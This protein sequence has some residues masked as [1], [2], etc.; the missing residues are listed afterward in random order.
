MKDVDQSLTHY[1]SR[2]K[3]TYATAP[4]MA[5]CGSSKEKG[6]FNGKKCFNGK[7]LFYQLHLLPLI[8]FLPLKHLLSLLLSLY[9]ICGSVISTVKI[10]STSYTFF[11]GNTF[12]PVPLKHPFFLL[13]PLCVICGSVVFVGSCVIPRHIWFP[14][15]FFM[16]SYMEY[17]NW[18]LIIP[19]ANH[20]QHWQSK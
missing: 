5:Y 3:S 2:E 13:L 16:L 20:N 18:L 1:S 12:Y 17:V 6:C 14:P 9:A 8:H 7:H 15:Y 10:C 19:D 4:H 11:G